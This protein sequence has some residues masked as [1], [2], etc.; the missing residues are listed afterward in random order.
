MKARKHPSVAHHGKSSL[1]NL[2]S[3]T[4]EAQKYCDLQDKAPLAWP[5]RLPSSGKD[6]PTLTTASSSATAFFTAVITWKQ[7]TLI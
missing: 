5:Q 1:S 6:S 4:S 7:D 3:G 2:P